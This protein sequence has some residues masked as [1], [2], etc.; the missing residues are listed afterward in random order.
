MIDMF[1]HTQ[2]LVEMGVSV[3]FCWTYL[4]TAVL[5]ISASQVA[6][7]TG[8]SHLCPAVVTF[9]MKHNFYWKHE[10]VADKL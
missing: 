2:L 8:M 3:T 5:L 7:M 10:L 1:Y 6:R 9:F 4:S